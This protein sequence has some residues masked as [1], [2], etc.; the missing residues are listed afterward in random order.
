[1]T[2]KQLIS[3]SMRRPDVASMLIWRCFKDRNSVS[4]AGEWL[5]YETISKWSLTTVWL[6]WTNGLL[7]LINSMVTELIRPVNAYQIRDK[8]LWM[9]TAWVQWRKWWN[10]GL[11]ALYTPLLP[12]RSCACWVDHCAKVF[13]S[14]STS[15]RATVV[16]EKKTSK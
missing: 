12:L 10:W 4:V 15:P 5:Q 16:P 13:A 1:M 14:F 3:T 8:L 9:F 7:R 6:N 11:F 2:S